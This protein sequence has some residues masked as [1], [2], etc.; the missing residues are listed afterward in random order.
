MKTEVGCSYETF[1]P[2]IPHG[3]TSLKKIALLLKMHAG[4]QPIMS[5][6]R[7]DHF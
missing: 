5:E 4:I 3:V 2:V 7:V 6:I 1:V